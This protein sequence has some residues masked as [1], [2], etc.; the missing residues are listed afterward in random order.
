MNDLV[1]QFKE[2]WGPLGTNQKISLI[3][4]SGLVSLAMIAMMIWAAQPDM[5]LLYGNLSTEEAGEIASKLEAKGIAHEFKA[6][7]SSIYVDSG[8][9]YD[10]RAQ[11][12]AEGIVPNGTGPG[13]E[14]FDKG[15]FGISDFAQRVNFNRAI[16]G[17]LERTISRFKG[18]TS[19]H[20]MV[21]MPSNQLVIARNDQDNPTAS[22]MVETSGGL[23]LPA[24]NSIRHLVANSVQGLVA[25]NVVVVDS[26]GKTLSEELQDDGLGGGLTTALI[27]YRKNT[28]S[29][30]THKVQTV[31]DR[32][33][34]PGQSEVLVA[35]DV[36]TTS[37]TTTQTTFD[38]DSQVA[39]SSNSQ[40]TKTETTESSG[41][42][43]GPAGIDANLPNQ[44]PGIVTP[45]VSNSDTSETKDEEFEINSMESIS[46]QNPGDIKK[47]T[48]SLLVAKR[49]K[50]DGQNQ[51]A[52]PRTPEE[53]D[54]LRRIVV[55]A[56]GIDNQNPDD[57]T[58]KEMDFAP[59]PLQYSA[60]VVE[61]SLKMDQWIGIAKTALGALLG[62][63]VVMFFLKMLKNNQ[64]EQ[65]SVEVLK[66]EQMLQASKLDDT[67]VVT[68][69]MLNELI[70][71][72]P[73]NIGVT[74]REW[75]GDPETA[76]K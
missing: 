6:G 58:V 3:L 54:E 56:L 50:T 42:G 52:D 70:R 65:I 27:R 55:N 74:L 22:V 7:G 36:D 39:R 10:L 53:L 30:F 25:E 46:I 16:K 62:I 20:V 24:V 2:L 63:G 48:A 31:L 66:P 69:E 37:V 51:V 67:S 49:Y 1:N 29:Y 33:L 41:N 4:A 23:A 13:L 47:V 14:L 72:K 9:V 57:V 60:D 34:G 19:A 61:R 35:V 64:P 8:K 12:S 44:A 68:P 59:N 5:Q 43:G 15:N 71:Q 32:V 17:E 40:K 38:P 76:N 45:V 28:E 11:L 26:F 75:I 18:V 73:A 21:V